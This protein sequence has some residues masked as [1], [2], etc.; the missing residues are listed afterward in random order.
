MPLIGSL[1]AASARGFGEFLVTPLVGPIGQQAYTTPGTF[2][3]VC[4][5][6]VTSV[7]VVAVGG[8]TPAYGVAAGGGGAGGLGYTNNIAVTPG[9]SYTVVVGAVSSGP[10]TAAGDS[11]FISTATVKGGG[12]SNYYTGGTYAGT[13]G[14]NGGASAGNFG[15]GAGGA[16]G[17]TG[18]GGNGVSV[19]GNGTNGAGGGG[20]GGGGGTSQ[21]QFVP[22][23]GYG[24]ISGPC[25]G[26]GGV[27]ILGQ[28]ANGT[29]GTGGG[30]GTTQAP[31]VGGGGGSGGGSGGSPS[32]STSAGGNGGAYGAS[33]GS[34]SG[35][36]GV[37][38][39]YVTSSDG[40]SVGGAVRIIWGTPRTFP[41][42]NTG[43]L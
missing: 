40:T 20:G 31:G 12:A 15:S 21:D 27:G 42:K 14:G 30:N 2:S 34:G 18:N 38:Y 5:T 43:N 4:P 29:G 33:A 35:G 28:G 8:A 37:G 9:N 11:Y 22:G 1:G 17:Y 39:T 26:G 23:V 13:G 24:Y 19:G 10:N 6:G 16:G 41:S 3:W 36:G 25:G 7:S 32:S